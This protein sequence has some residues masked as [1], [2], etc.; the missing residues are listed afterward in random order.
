MY[1]CMYVCMY[2]WVAVSLEII[3]ILLIY[4]IKFDGFRPF[5]CGIGWPTAYT[6]YVCTYITV[7]CMSVCIYVC[8]KSNIC[9]V[10]SCTYSE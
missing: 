4:K 1:V 2:M 10:E 8:Y 7:I 6:R 3:K 5:T 9:Q